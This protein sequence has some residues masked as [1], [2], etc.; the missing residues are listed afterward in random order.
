MATT[1]MEKKIESSRFMNR[2]TIYKN[3]FRAKKK[4]KIRSEPPII[5]LPYV[6]KQR[7]NVATVMKAMTAHVLK[8]ITN[9]PALIQTQK[10]LTFH[11]S[12]IL[13]RFKN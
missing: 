9:L 4:Y 2:H 5:S 7:Q 10:I 8:A 6:D 11:F 13:K 3:T 12:Q 1:I